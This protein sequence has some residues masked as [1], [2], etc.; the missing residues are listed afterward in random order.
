MTE[1]QGGLGDLKGY[2]PQ[3]ALAR[4]DFDDIEVLQGFDLLN[5]S[6]NIRMGVYG[7]SGTGKTF[8]IFSM[9]EDSCEVRAD[10]DEWIKD[11][12]AHNQELCNYVLSQDIVGRR[13]MLREA[14]TVIL[15]DWDNRGTEKL[16]AAFTANPML[17]ECIHYIGINDWESA[18]KGLNKALQIAEEHVARGVGR[19][20]LWIV[21]DNMEE[22][23]SEVQSD[24]TRAT[25]GM[26]A[27]ELRNKARVDNPGTDKAAMSAQSKAIASEM[28]WGHI[29]AAHKE[30]FKPLLNQDIN[31]MVM[32][33]P[34]DRE[35]ESVLPGGGYLK[36][37]VPSIGGIKALIFYLDWVVGRYQTPDKTAR[38]AKFK[39][40]RWTG[41]ITRTV[42]D[43]TY[44]NI[45]IEMER[46]TRQHIQLQLAKYKQR[47]YLDTVPVEVEQWIKPRDASKR[48]KLA[49]LPDVQT[50]APT[51]PPPNGG[52]GDIAKVIPPPKIMV[53]P[54]P[55]IPATPPPPPVIPG[56]QIQAP[57]ITPPLPVTPAPQ[58]PLPPSLVSKETIEIL[59]KKSDGIA[60]DEL[61][62]VLG[63]TTP[64]QEEQ[65]DNLIFELLETDQVYEPK[66]AWI[67][68][69]TVPSPP[70]PPPAPQAPPAPPTPVPQPVPQKP[71]PK[72]KE[73]APLTGGYFIISALDNGRGPYHSPGCGQASRLKR[74]LKMTH[75]GNRKQCGKCKPLAVEEG[76]E[77]A[78]V[79]VEDKSEAKSDAQ[80]GW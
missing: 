43:P 18:T 23:W 4:Q 15:M 26:T 66:L 1:Q 70:A 57:T 47:A 67:K 8:T 30:W 61:M 40:C 48:I 78:F 62:T 34:K 12:F 11:V 75:P 76:D 27:T 77:I 14:F 33:P 46:V 20:G 17:Y 16:A 36:E 9:L 31:I 21:I 65:V 68:L 73:V 19:R 55:V 39:K 64:A 41:I 45:R 10:D 5:I 52:F 54:P 58:T 79:D 6:K 7:D 49:D 37:K 38:Y 29:N 44:T 22:A 13:T 53:P 56:P 24:Y 32:A 63:V 72:P 42:S 60:I 69:N 74:K 71:T 2:I 51:I 35:T 80:G 50:P 3:T 28:N 25:T 59:T